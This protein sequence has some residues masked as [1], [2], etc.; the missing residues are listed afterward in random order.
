MYAN[1]SSPMKENRNSLRFRDQELVSYES[2]ENPFKMEQLFPPLSLRSEGRKTPLQG[3]KEKN[4]NNKF[5][6]VKKVK[7]TKRDRPIDRAVG[8]F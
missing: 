2:E 7:M 3:K 5:L 6:N 8:S 1:V 4:M